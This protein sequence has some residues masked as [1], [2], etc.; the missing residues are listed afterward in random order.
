[1]DWRETRYTLAGE[2]LEPMVAEHG[3]ED[4]K[5]L[6]LNDEKLLRILFGRRGLCNIDTIRNI[7]AAWFDRIDWKKPEFFSG[8]DEEPI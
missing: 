2:I 5:R 4:V 8:I 1:M 7:A 6:L 3:K